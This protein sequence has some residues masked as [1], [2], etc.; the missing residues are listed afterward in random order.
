MSI[1]QNESKYYSKYCKISKYYKKYRNKYCKISKYCKVLKYGKYCPTYCKISKYCNTYYNILKYCNSI[2]KHQSI[3]ILCNTIGPTPAH[4]GVQAL[5]AFVT[6][7]VFMILYRQSGWF[8]SC[9]TL[10][11]IDPISQSNTH[12]QSSTAYTFGDFFLIKYI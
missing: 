2:A 9:E 5:G 3:A 12:N 7:I 10:M 11:I 4:Y 1:D 6:M 8:W